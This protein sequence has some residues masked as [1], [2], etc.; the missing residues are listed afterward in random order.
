MMRSSRAIWKALSRTSRKSL[1]RRAASTAA[2]LVSPE[3]ANGLAVAAPLAA[4]AVFL[5]PLLS[6]KKWK[7]EGTGDA[8][9]LPFSAMTANGALWIVYGL[10]QSD[11]TIITANLSAFAFG[12]Y[13]LR[14]FDTFRSSLELNMVPHYA[15][16]AGIAS[17]CGAMALTLPHETATFA[18][19]T[20]GC[21]V[22]AIH[23]WGGKESMFEEANETLLKL[24]D[25]KY[26]THRSGRRKIEKML[27]EARWYQAVQPRY[28]AD[29]KR[30]IMRAPTAEQQRYIAEAK[31]PPTVEQLPP[32]PPQESAEAI[33]R[34]RKLTISQKPE[35]LQQLR[36]IFKL[37][38]SS[39]VESSLVE[40]H[41]ACVIA[42]VEG[43]NPEVTILEWFTYKYP[44][45]L[46]R[47][48]RIEN[49]A[50]RTIKRAWRAYLLRVHFS[51]L[52]RISRTRNSASRTL[53]CAWNFFQFRKRV[54]QRDMEAF[55]LGIL[56]AISSSAVETVEHARARALQLI[57][58]QHILAEEATMKR[59][60]QGQMERLR[61]LEEQANAKKKRKAAAEALQRVW[62]GKSARI[63][64]L[65]R[66]TKLE[67]TAASTVQRFWRC[68]KARKRMHGLAEIARAERKL[69]KQNAAASIIQNNFR[70]RIRAPNWCQ[71]LVY[72]LQVRDI[73]GADDELPLSKDLSHCNMTYQAMVMGSIGPYKQKEGEEEEEEEEEDRYGV[74]FS[75][76]ATPLSTAWRIFD[77]PKGRGEKRA[78]YGARRYQSTSTGRM[79]AARNARVELASTLHMVGMLKSAEL[80]WKE[81]VMWVLSTASLQGKFPGKKTPGTNY[82]GAHRWRQVVR[83][84]LI[85][86]I[87]LQLAP[88]SAAYLVQLALTLQ[89]QG[90][91]EQAE[92]FLTMVFVLFAQMK[93]RVD[94][95]D[96]LRRKTQ[97]KNNF[98][99]LYKRV[100]VLTNAELLRRVMQLCE[101]SWQSKLQS[102]FARWHRESLLSES[103]V[104]WATLMAQKLIRG[105]QGRIRA[106]RARRVKAI[107][108]HVLL[109]AVIDVQRAWR[110]RYRQIVHMV[111]K[112]QTRWRMKTS[113]RNFCGIAHL[114]HERAEAQRIKDKELLLK[115]KDLKERILALGRP[116]RSH[117]Y[118]VKRATV[119]AERLQ[120]AIRSA[121]K[122]KRS[123]RKRL[124][125]VIARTGDLVIEEKK[126]IIKK[127][128]ED[129]AQ[130][131]GYSKEK[132]EKMITK[133]VLGMKLKSY[134][135]REDEY[136][137]YKEACDDADAVKVSAARAAAALD[138]FRN[139]KG[140][141]NTVQ[142]R[143]ER[144]QKQLQDEA[145]YRIVAL[146]RSTIIRNLVRRRVGLDKETEFLRTW[147]ATQFQR[148]WRSFAARRFVRTT[149]H[150]QKG[151]RGTELQ[152]KLANALGWRT[153]DA[154]SRQ[155]A[156]QRLARMKMTES[157]LQQAL[158]LRNR[159]RRRPMSI[160]KYRK[161]SQEERALV[162][163]HRRPRQ[164]KQERGR[165]RLSNFFV[166][167]HVLVGDFGAVRTPYKETA[168]DAYVRL[169]VVV[170]VVNKLAHHKPGFQTY[171]MWEL[172]NAIQERG[173]TLLIK[174]VRFDDIPGVQNPQK[175]GIWRVPL[176]DDERG[177]LHR[178]PWGDEMY[179]KM[180]KRAKEG[181]SQEDLD[182]EEAAKRKA[183]QEAAR[184]KPGIPG[185]DMV[186][187]SI[188]E[189]GSEW[190]G[191][192]RTAKS[193]GIKI[194]HRKDVLTSDVLGK[195]FKILKPL[196]LGERMDP[197]LLEMGAVT[198]EEA[199]AGVKKAA[200]SD[201]ERAFILAGGQ[202]RDAKKKAF[203][204]L[205]ELRSKKPG[206][207][208]APAIMC[209][210]CAHDDP[211][212]LRP[213]ERLCHNCDMPY[214][215][216]CFRG[217]HRA[218]HMRFHT[219]TFYETRA[220]HLPRHESGPVEAQHNEYL[221]H[222][223]STHPM[224]YHRMSQAHDWKWSDFDLRRSVELFLE[225][226]WRHEHGLDQDK[227]RRIVKMLINAKNAQSSAINTALRRSW[228][229]MDFPEA[230]TFLQFVELMPIFYRLYLKKIKENLAKG[231]AL[232][233]ELD[234]SKWV[235]K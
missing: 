45:L 8:S 27:N 187:M 210:A 120:K 65:T 112:V 32:L 90:L 74:P 28:I 126:R 171:T 149:L 48:K 156:I 52:V 211:P 19:G 186:A 228:R 94:A 106:W 203:D 138:E 144:L 29:A 222:L 193:D 57:R 70:I 24:D 189:I 206:H 146:F 14:T 176:F 115:I 191:S 214:C 78:V 128:I 167:M 229:I 46:Q 131:M 199:A 161:L 102:K 109:C 130:I 208:S 15:G 80:V 40:L 219:W 218:F 216:Q 100:Q 85:P 1:H 9:P 200:I 18:I 41:K 154:D 84:R 113:Y 175:Y 181:V 183:A 13:Y 50:V 145:S 233:R 182:A 91:Y 179:T 96:A 35:F 143:L 134:R 118:D 174:P 136:R 125:E 170:K 103:T 51:T 25:R 60:Q 177:D 215:R 160:R 195:G 140:E 36:Q 101:R 158:R 147:A 192:G 86:A 39:H 55:I 205:T 178:S 123:R 135:Q 66:R 168:M 43:G 148:L 151:A 227:I 105:R 49:K 21:C 226:D 95:A 33:L 190:D 6:V 137:K 73:I 83:T 69:A 185:Y 3:V 212:S 30:H 34:R 235:S 217:A 12:A 63:A 225:L 224:Q 114:A 16:A 53:Q 142:V 7:S 81:L 230:I 209:A 77:S 99:A 166:D 152:I 198:E 223:Q 93:A 188:H 129:E 47:D 163:S 108:D 231:T 201:E 22:V 31:R 133:V 141:E 5:A 20:L 127:E 180:I 234:W 155:R 117:E 172:S 124:R 207:P 221:A 165:E 38:T 71:R 92:P 162:P 122:R 157:R 88:R 4:Q 54:R 44:L 139:T 164:T 59:K 116:I 37:R 159:F 97:L 173:G 2:A 89:A 107:R 98:G 11:M 75:L 213:A 110:K 42:E 153:S 121:E 61:F 82:R 220:S 194:I 104:Q 64:V 232:S 111:T 119:H 196:A 56:Q 76:G 197:W 72:A 204:M 23:A 79:V 62:R 132:T 10:L 87:R 26:R 169:K 58:E 184:W 17:A 68:A 67:N 150:N 202:V